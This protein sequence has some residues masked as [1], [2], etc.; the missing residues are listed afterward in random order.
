MEHHLASIAEIGVSDV[1][2]WGRARIWWDTKNDGRKVMAGRE[3]QI[4]TGNIGISGPGKNG[5]HCGTYKTQEQ[6]N[7][8]RVSKQ[9][10]QHLVYIWRAHGGQLECRTVSYSGS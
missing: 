4:E 1:V 10:G 5:S 2:L 9:S 3:G 7:R 6:G 8:V